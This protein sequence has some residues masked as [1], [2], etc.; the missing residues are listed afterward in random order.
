M[1]KL[2]SILAASAVLGFGSAAW[3]QRTVCR[4]PLKEAAGACVAQCPGGYEDRGTICVYR[5]QA[6]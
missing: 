2:I 1:R 6:H 5:N 3:A 4:P